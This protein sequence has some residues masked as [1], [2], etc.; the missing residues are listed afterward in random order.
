MDVVDLALCSLSAAAAFG[1]GVTGASLAA[2]RLRHASSTARTL[3]R[4]DMGG[5]AWLLRNG[6]AVTKPLARRLLGLAALAALVREGVWAL[7]ERGV[8]TNEEALLSL[9]VAVVALA[10]AVSA[11]ATASVLAGLAVACCAVACLVAWARS[12]QEGRREAL[13]DA[14]PEALSSMGACFHSGYSLLQTFRQVAEETEGPLSRLFESAAHR[15]EVGRS[16]AEALAVLREG[17]TVS[18]LAFVIVAL[19]VQHQTGGSMQRVLDAA[20]ETVEGQVE[21]RRS[22]RVQTAQARL[23]ARVVSLM[24]F[25]LVA[26]FSLVSEDFLDPFFESAT[27]LALLGLALAMEAAGVLAVRRMLR[28]EVS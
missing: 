14:V 19:D 18:E 17:A 26:L 4:D 6:M 11:L 25:V 8:E 7:E 1:F 27:G 16:S 23:S 12:A 2:A 9:V 28:I 5:V 24:P 22:L 10:G 13:R 21:L 15:L 3:A 20:S